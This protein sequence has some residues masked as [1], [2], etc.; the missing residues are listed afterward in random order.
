[1][2]YLFAYMHNVHNVRVLFFIYIV[3]FSMHT[4][5]RF[6]NGLYSYACR[7][8]EKLYVRII[9]IE[10]FVELAPTFSLHYTKYNLRTLDMCN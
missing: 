7:G 6:V 5:H 3:L 1:M 4:L 9:Q 2:I 8:V 10:P